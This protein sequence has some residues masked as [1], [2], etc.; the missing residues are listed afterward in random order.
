MRREI[1]EQLLDLNIYLE[2]E[3]AVS[4]K[5]KVFLFMMNDDGKH[6]ESDSAGEL[7][8]LF[9]SAVAHLT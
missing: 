7:S 6:P 3:A 2:I 8:A 5:K 1:A 9:M 4:K